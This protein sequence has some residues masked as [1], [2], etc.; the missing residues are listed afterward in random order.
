MSGTLDQVLEMLGTERARA[1]LMRRKLT[2]A[3]QYPAFVLIAA[4]CVMLFF[5]LF[6]LPQFS[7]VLQDFGAKSDSALNVFIRLSDFLR[8]NATL[9]LVASAG[10]I[11][12]VWWLLRRPG[13]RAVAVNT[14]SRIPGIAGIFDFYRTT[15][16][17][18]NLGVLLGSGVSLTATLRIL[19]DIMAV[20]GNVTTWTAAA[21]RVRHGG[22]LSDALSASNNLPPMALRMLRLGEETG[23][24][25][26][27][28]GR[29]AEFYEQKLQRSLDRIVGIIGP[30]AIVTI[31]AV[32]GGLIVSV[33]T[34]LLSVTQLVG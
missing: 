3:M 21:D 18:R 19:V 9:V 25:P 24:L 27:L 8:A 13:T 31:S 14:I 34:A 10:F 12:G 26:A 23:Q 29:V 6:V 22:K 15:L 11:V 20:T 17:C 5:I 4:V 33:M 16:F 7:S 28:A 1:E 30:L 32:V 2:D